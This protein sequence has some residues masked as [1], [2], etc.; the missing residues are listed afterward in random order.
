MKHLNNN[1][2]GILCDNCIYS[3][4]NV[5]KPLSSDLITSKITQQV[6]SDESVYKRILKK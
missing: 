3:L 1:L 2:C 5:L 4:K 6:F